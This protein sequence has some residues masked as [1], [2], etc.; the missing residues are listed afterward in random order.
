[1]IKKFITIILISLIWNTPLFSAENSS[2][3]S[4]EPNSDGRDDTGYH[5]AKKNKAGYGE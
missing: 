2:N 5:S 4:S 3:S 1:M